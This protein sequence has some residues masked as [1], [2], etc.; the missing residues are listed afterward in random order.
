[1]EIDHEIFSA[2]ISSLPMIPEGLLSVADVS[3]HRVLVNH[4]VHACPKKSVVRLTDRL[5]MTIA[6][7]WE[8]KPQTK[9]KKSDKMNTCCKFSLKQKQKEEEER[10]KIEEEKVCNLPLHKLGLVATKR[11]FGV[12]DKAT[13]K[14]VSSATGT[15]QKIEISL[16]A[17]LDMII[18]KT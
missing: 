4:L 17:S 10:K 6:V 11:V 3:I 8:I 15:S 18:S 2:V 9:Q 1:M 16:V 12:S 7:D 13:Q 14:S 5:D